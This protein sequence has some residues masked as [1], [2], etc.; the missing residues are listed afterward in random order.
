[1]PNNT[2]DT[3]SIFVGEIASRKY[4]CQIIKSGKYQILETGDIVSSNKTKDRRKHLENIK[5][6]RYYQESLKDTV[7]M[8]E[9]KE[10]ESRINTE[11]YVEKHDITSLFLRD[12]GGVCRYIDVAS[13]K[14]LFKRIT[15]NNQT[16]DIPVNHNCNV[17]IYCLKDE[18]PF[19]EIVREE[20]MKPQMTIDEI[21]EEVRLFE[22]SIR[23]QAETEAES[24]EGQKQEEKPQ[25][26]RPKSLFKTIFR[27]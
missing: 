3:N 1:M 2:I 21:N 6:C 11:G 4:I 19:L 17:D 25:T 15:Q 24:E 12:I 13:N 23:I 7:T 14:G 5:P 20:K 8:K 18:I 10:L 27:K 22:L 16:I 9:L 26:Q